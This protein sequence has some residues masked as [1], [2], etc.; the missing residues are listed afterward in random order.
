M[1]RIFLFALN[2][3]CGS[4]QGTAETNLLACLKFPT[5]FNFTFNSNFPSLDNRLPCW[6]LQQFN[7]SVALRYWSYYT[8][9]AGVRH[10]GCPFLM[11][12]TN[13]KPLQQFS[14]LIYK[15]EPFHQSPCATSTDHLLQFYL[16]A[17]CCLSGNDLCGCL[18]I[19]NV[20][21]LHFSYHMDSMDWRLTCSVIGSLTPLPTESGI[22]WIEV[23]VWLPITF[24][25]IDWFARAAA[26]ERHPLQVHPE[27]WGTV[28][29]KTR[30]TTLWILGT[31][32]TKCTKCN[33]GIE[34][35]CFW[36]S[37]SSR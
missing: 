20:S 36:Y 9:M 28:E 2:L 3:S 27:G 7:S 25:A 1:N 15:Q 10:P 11:P 23:Y 37:P 6:L 12:K 34:L 8:T 22:L 30:E 19:W 5:F 13:R 21:C 14:S 33:W 4:K 26:M 16:P 18:R 24:L 31:K 17:K 35:L 32:W 29:W